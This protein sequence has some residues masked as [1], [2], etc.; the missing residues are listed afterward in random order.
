MEHPYE[1]AAAAASTGPLLDDYLHMA[2]QKLEP[3]VEQYRH[4]LVAQVLDE[5]KQFK[6][7]PLTVGVAITVALMFVVARCAGLGA[8]PAAAQKP[9]KKKKKVSKAQMANRQ[10]QAVL[11]FVELV[12]VPQIDSYILNYKQ[13][14]QD[15]ITYKYNYFEEMLLKELMKLDEVEVTGNDI[16]RE[17][18]R[19]VIKFIQDHQKR[20]DKFRLEV[21]F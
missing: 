18:R 2:Q 9:K 8:E 1:P 5:L 13:L 16:L 10:I 3:I 20:L 6:V 7:T 19:K 17:N 12:Y 21:G 15:D 4:A 11:D 14:S